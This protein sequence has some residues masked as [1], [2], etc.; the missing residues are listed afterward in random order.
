MPRPPS[1]AVSSPS[2]T[3]ASPV[4]LMV[5][6][7]QME[8][9][10]DDEMGEVIVERQFFRRRLAGDGLLCKDQIADERPEYIG[11]RARGGKRQHVGGLVLAAIAPVEDLHMGIV[12][13]QQA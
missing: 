12:G 4:V 13:E 2:I 8:Q 5:I 3:A 6:V 1:I 11:C 7:Q 10:V 9:A